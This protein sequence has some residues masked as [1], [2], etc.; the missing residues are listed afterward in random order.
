MKCTEQRV[1]QL[2]HILSQFPDKMYRC[3]RKTFAW[4]ENKNSRSAN[5]FASGWTRVLNLQ[6]VESHL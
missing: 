5:A 2:R 3:K 4:S 6:Y 1:K